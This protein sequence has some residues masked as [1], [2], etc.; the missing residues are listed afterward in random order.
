MQSKA[1][2]A[3]DWRKRERKKSAIS[4][5]TLTKLV[6]ESGFPDPVED[7]GWMGMDSDAIAGKYHTFLRKVAEE[8]ERLNVGDVTR[9]LR[10]QW[11]MTHEFAD[12]L[13]QKLCHSF[14]KF[15]KLVGRPSFTGRSFEP[16]VRDLIY[17][18]K[19]GRLNI[20]PSGASASPSPSPSPSPPPGMR[21]SEAASRIWQTVKKE[22]TVVK[23]E[24]VRQS[25]A[26]AAAARH[27]ESDTAASLWSSFSCPLVPRDEA[28]AVAAPVPKVI[29]FVIKINRIIKLLITMR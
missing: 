16:N 10:G 13:A 15:S 14:A 2:A 9:A 27:S 20:G 6:K 1:C 21:Q 4:V 25:E 7:D 19:K 3:D 24:P 17:T 12:F 22:E 18:L 8:T 29:I 23:Q 5:A 26:S 28:K 11:E